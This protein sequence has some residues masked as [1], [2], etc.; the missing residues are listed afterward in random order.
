MCNQKLQAQNE[1]NHGILL[2]QGDTEAI[3]GWGTPAG[4]WRAWRR[5][6]L[7]ARGAQ[8]APGKQVLEIGCGT[9]M[10]TEMFARSGASIVA[11]DISARL[12]GKAYARLIRNFSGSLFITAVK[13]ITGSGSTRNG[14]AYTCNERQKR[15]RV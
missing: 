4:R 14:S 11:V 8:L 5:A 1:I 9:G 12:L 6:S 15:S 10:F 7:I 3:W 2:S 13:P